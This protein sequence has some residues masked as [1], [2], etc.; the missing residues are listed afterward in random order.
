[1][2]LKIGIIGYGKMGKML[3]QASTAKGHSV[4]WIANNSEELLEKL[5][6]NTADVAIEFST[7]DSV[8]ISIQHC[9]NFNL[10]IVVGTTG[11]LKH[12]PEVSKQV[13]DANGSIIYASNYSLTANLFFAMIEKAGQ[14]LSGFPDNYQVAIEETHHT[15][16]LDKPSGT[17]LTMVDKFISNNGKYN[18]W[19][20]V[21]D[22]NI[23]QDIV[24]VTAH[25]IG[26]VVGDHSLKISTHMDELLIQHKAID[27]M[28][29]A[30]GAILAATFIHNKK[31]I[32]TAKDLYPF[33]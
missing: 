26:D 15:Q 16:K 25:R 1:M 29:F 13:A 9:L 10:P 21:D 14:W 27:R 33:N 24:P 3:E 11:W 32:F 2:I 28:T 7:P 5:A 4:S 18:S 12:L 22:D 31:G 17:A 20:L 30:E 6:D 23:T 8:L 19:Q